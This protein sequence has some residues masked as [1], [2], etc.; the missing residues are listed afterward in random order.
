MKRSITVSYEPNI[1]GK[2]GGGSR[3][4]DLLACAL[5]KVLADTV[6]KKKIGRFE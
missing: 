1:S 3:F 2:H 6:G 5:Q 4:P